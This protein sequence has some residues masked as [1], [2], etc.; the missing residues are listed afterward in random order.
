[1]T[2]WTSETARRLVLAVGA[3]SCGGPL[4]A[5]EAPGRDAADPDAPVPTAASTADP[6]RSSAFAPGEV[7]EAHHAHHAHPAK[8]TEAPR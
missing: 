7:G 4:P 2:A 8:Q 1:V 5:P 3:C 6:L